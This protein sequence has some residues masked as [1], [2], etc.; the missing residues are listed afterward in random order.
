MKYL[1]KGLLKIL[2][3]VILLPIL[4]PLM[5]ID[6]VMWI[7]GADPMNTPIRRFI[8]NSGLFESL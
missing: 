2:V 3:L 5:V 4:L 8:D 6:I 1:L 7:G